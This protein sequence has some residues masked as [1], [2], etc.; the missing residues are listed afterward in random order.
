MKSLLIV[1]EAFEVG[2][3]ETHIKGE[4]IS[5]SQTGCRV[6]LA[7]GCRFNR[8]LLPSEIASLTYDLPLGPEAT[9]TELIQAVE[10]LRYIIREHAIE[11]IHAHPFTSLLPSLIAAELEKIPL[12]LTLHGPASLAS[13]YGPV[14]DFILTSILLPNASLVIAVSKEIADLAS[15]YLFQDQLFILANGINTDIFASKTTTTD[16]TDS[17]W[18]LVSRLDSLKIAGITDF[19]RKAK[20]A[21]LPG[22]LLAGD[23]PAKEEL[24]NR[25]SHDDTLDFVEFCGARAD[26]PQLMQSVTGIAGMGRVVLEGLASCK[27]VCLVG[28]DGVKGLVDQTLFFQASY[29]N[30]SGRNLGNIDETTFRHQIEC[31]A[32]INIPGLHG[33]VR[34]HFTETRLWTNFQKRIGTLNPMTPTLLGDCYRAL[35]AG[36]IAEDIPFLQSPIV[37]EQIGK[38]VHSS[39]YAQAALTNSYLYYRDQFNSN[40]LV[41]NL[42][43]ANE[44][45]VN[46]NQSIAERNKQIADLSQSLVERDTQIADLNQTII[47]RDAQITNLNQAVIERNAQISGMRAELSAMVAMCQKMRASRSWRITAPLRFAGRFMRYGLLSDDRMWI[48]KRLRSI[49]QR[50]PV[51]KAIKTAIRGWYVRLFGRPLQDSSLQ[52]FLGKSPVNEYLSSQ[53]QVLSEQSN[54]F[55]TP[56]HWE[57]RHK[58]YGILMLP[59]IDWHFRFQR[60]QQLARQFARKGHS[61]AY[62]SLNFG[63]ALS[64]SSLEEGIEGLLLPGRKGINVYQETPTQVDVDQMVDALLQYI[65]TVPQRL[66]VCIVQLPYW[67]QIATQLKN[68]SGCHIIY[69]CMDDHAGFSTNGE[70]MLATEN[71]LMQQAD[72]VVASSTLLFNKAQTLSQHTVLIRNAVD[73]PHF[74]A[75]PEKLHTPSSTLIV[76]YY[77]AIA[78]WFDSSLVAELARLRPSWH[79]VL[80]GSTFS[81]D[82]A[83]LTAYPNISL[84]GEQPYTELPRLIADWDCCIIPFKRLPLTEATNPVKV[85]EMLAAGK[86]IVA[87][88]LPELIPI[89][90]AGHIALADT[91]ETF[92]QAIE[93]EVNQDTS[94]RQEARRRYA[95]EN[96]WKVRQEALDQAIRETYPLVSIIIVTYNNLPLNRLCLESVLNDTDYPNFEVI[97]IDNASS[98]DT[99]SYLKNLHHPKL[100][101][102]LNDANRG[103]SAANN[104]GLATAR[105]KFLCLLNN[106]TVVANSWLTTLVRHLQLNPDLGLVGP[107]TNAIDNEAKISVGYR[108]LLDMPAW[109]ATYYRNMNGCLEDISMLAFFCVVMPRS[110]FETVGPL[111]ERFGIGMFEDDDYNRRVQAAGFK[112]KLARDA[113]IHHWQCASFKLLGKETYLETFYENKKKYQ[114]KWAADTLKADEA[115]KL[116]KLIET[117]NNSARTII[118]APS[119]GW[120]VHLFQRPHHFARVLAQ[121]GYTVVFDCSN[122]QDDVALLKEIEP[123]LFLFKGEAELLANLHNPVLW[124][125]TYNYAY[126]DRFPRDIPVI[127]DWIDD[128]SVFPFDQI[129]L[130][131][132]HARA[133]K[134]ATVVAS[135][136]RNLHENALKERPDAI[137]LPNAVE[138]GRFD[139]PPTPNPALEDKVFSRIVSAGKFIAGYYGALAEWFDYELLARTAE[140]LPDWHF[141]LIGPDYD[142]SIKKSRIISHQ[143]ITWLGPRDYQTLPGYLHLF[144][145]AMI[146]F[147]INEIT[148]ATSPLKLFEYFAGGKP[149]VTTPMP[150]CT[151]FTEVCI[152]NNAEE[153]SAALRSAKDLAKKPEYLHRLAALTQGNTWRSRTHH[154]F[155]A[156]S[157]QQEIEDS[158]AISHA[159]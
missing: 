1:T 74:A 103:F 131:Q 3:L 50:L 119:I 153:F 42:M 107:V 136:A 61:V 94:S 38:V 71:K 54:E 77:G 123:R 7:T 145:V 36:Q 148:L 9:L 102:I 134:E 152:A 58:P 70:K 91:A 52:S 115:E 83:P 105:G 133:I 53:P 4:I 20:A 69:D 31:L 112:V 140:L 35:M 17:R 141:V 82:T 75:V 76:G 85:Y 63:T 49:F 47:E 19:I 48:E 32:K 51:S 146:P 56:E 106:D 44:Q 81:G 139:Q 93:R 13:F 127:Y 41:K 100:T 72:L 156:L 78:D 86:T 28:Y 158:H 95:S 137:Y 46:L 101:I 109:A 147:R 135:V 120:N 12:I 24:A 11:Y 21:G 154:V 97:V 59:I 149:V 118:F 27:P 43:E 65:S 15:P 33:V 144:D 125:F 62:T 39:K 64:I 90:D 25:L 110:V 128:L 151:A 5:L 57:H 116:S 30:F 117:S 79:F 138:E 88:S 126:R 67:E 37:L 98:D 111:D 157:N 96:T 143:N 155:Y 18:L 14:Y 60:P 23:G 66:W 114:S 40:K 29:T 130:A 10:K 55:V 129:Q 80:I 150:E 22:V 92:A 108:N 104:Q 121:D 68:Q 122:N 113:Y 99:P 124:T 8:L 16:R 73:Y 6:H 89:S 45:I 26:I 84:Q 132:L 2:G 87:V 142:G 159:L 34:E